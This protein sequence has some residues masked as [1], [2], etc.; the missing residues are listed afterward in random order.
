MTASD[1][2]LLGWKDA[3]R[4]A[5]FRDEKITCDGNWHSSLAQMIGLWVARAPMSGV[6]RSLIRYPAFAMQKILMRSRGGVSTH[7]K[8]QSSLY[9]RNGSD[10][11]L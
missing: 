6:V 1:G 2:L 8:S 10:M 3:S 7:G 5:G 9:F 11:K 4:A